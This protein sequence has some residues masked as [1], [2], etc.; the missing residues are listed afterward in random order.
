MYARNRI[1]PGGRLRL[2]CNQTN[3]IVRRSGQFCL[4]SLCG[5]GAES[6]IEVPK[7]I[8]PLWG[9]NLTWPTLSLQ[10]VAEY[11]EP[12]WGDKR[13]TA[14]K[15]SWGGEACTTTLCRSWFYTLS[16]GSG[17]SATRP[18]NRASELLNIQ[19]KILVKRGPYV[20]YCRCNKFHPPPANTATIATSLYP[21]SVLCERWS[22]RLLAL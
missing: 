7:F 22:Y 17:N 5:R 1:I 20:F 19:G 9:I 16:N 3:T 14:R 12:D 4:D 10:S 2:G 13:T 15:A 18:M 21:I 6:Q 11:M 8:V